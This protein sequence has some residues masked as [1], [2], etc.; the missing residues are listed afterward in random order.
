MV[1]GVRLPWLRN[2][3]AEQDDEQKK[4]VVAELLK[5]F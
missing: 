4:P 1:A 2:R 5:V 3:W